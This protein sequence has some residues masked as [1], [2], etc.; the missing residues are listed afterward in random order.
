MYCRPGTS[1]RNLPTLGLWLWP[2][3][4]CFRIVAAQIEHDEALV[5]A[6]GV[7]ARLGLRIAAE[8]ADHDAVGVVLQI[9]VVA[10]ELFARVVPER[11]ADGELVAAVAVHVERIRIVP[12]LPVALPQQFELVVV[13]PEVRVAILDQDLAARRGCRRGSRRRWS[14]RCR[15]RRAAPCRPRASSASR[16]TLLTLPVRPSRIWSLKSLHQHDFVPAVAIDVVDLERRVVG[17]QAV[18]RI[19]PA[20]SATGPCRRG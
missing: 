15:A 14:R 7:D 2:T 13:D 20:R 12:G 18:A 19:G 6:A 8:V 11:V 3:R 1:G 17:E 4:M 10:P 9:L 16:P 5:A